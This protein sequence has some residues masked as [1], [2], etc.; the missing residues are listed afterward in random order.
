MLS[1]PAQNWQKVHPSLKSTSKLGV[2]SQITPRLYLT[3]YRTARNSEKLQELGITHVISIVEFRPDLPEVI[4]QTQRLH[5]A[6]SDTPESNILEHLDATTAFITAALE[7]NETN[8]VMVSN[9]L[10]S[11]MTYSFINWQV[12]CMLGISRSSTV[13]CAYLIATANLSAEES[14]AHVQSLRST[15]S[16]NIGFRQ[17]LSEYATRCVENKSK[18]NP[19]LMPDVLNGVG[20]EVIRRLRKRS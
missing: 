6:L 18:S 12:H 16:P 7:E 13:V 9:L 1:F 17:Q 3:D 19:M 4:P 11:S 8:K 14:I 2:A 5:L 20:G 10:G 15:V